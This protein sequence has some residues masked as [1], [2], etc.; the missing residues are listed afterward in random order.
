MKK[1]ELRALIEEHLVLRKRME[2]LREELKKLEERYDENLELIY[3]FRSR[4][5]LRSVFLHL[6]ELNGEYGK[7]QHF[8]DLA[9][10]VIHSLKNY[11][12]IEHRKNYTPKHLLRLYDERLE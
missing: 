5:F 7:D 4:E 3:L 12:N 8:I 2:T 11:K 1:E 10:S 6:K 9:H